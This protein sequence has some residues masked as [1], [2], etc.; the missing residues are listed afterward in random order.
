MSKSLSSFFSKKWLE[1]IAL[2]FF[3]IERCQWFACDS[4]K[5]LSKKWAISWEKK[6]RFPHF[7]FQKSI[8]LLLLFAQSLF[9]KDR[10]DRFTLA[11][12]YKRATVSKS[13]PSLFTKE[14]PWANWSPRSLKKSD[15]SDSLFFHQWIYLSITKNKRFAWKTYDRIP[16]PEYRDPSVDPMPFTRVRWPVPWDPPLLYV[17]TGNRHLSVSHPIIIVLVYMYNVLLTVESHVASITTTHLPAFPNWKT[18]R[19]LSFL[20]EL[21]LEIKNGLLRFPNY[22]ISHMYA[23]RKIIY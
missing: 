10:W 14:R 12:L 19:Q 3:K 11:A 17:D 7:L 23:D 16:N 6:H 5:S 18:F 15:L 8:L 21:L 2:D 4:T 20:K 9:F 1:Q 13:L 22:C